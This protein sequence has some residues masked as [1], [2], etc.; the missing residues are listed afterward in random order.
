MKYENLGLNKS[1]EF[2]NVLINV[3]FARDNVP[4]EAND[5]FYKAAF[6]QFSLFAYLCN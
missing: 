1:V 2:P 3:P 4:S 6:R 5:Q